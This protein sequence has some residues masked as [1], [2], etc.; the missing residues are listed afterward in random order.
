[1]RIA[2]KH[3]GWYAQGLCGGLRL[4]QAANIA[5]T[6]AAQQD[7]VNRFFDHL[8]LRGPRLDTLPASPD[9]VD[10]RASFGVRQQSLQGG[11]ALAA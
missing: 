10:A 7:A 4:R 5:G 2:R 6:S 3:L 8:A 9:V 1:M 11:E